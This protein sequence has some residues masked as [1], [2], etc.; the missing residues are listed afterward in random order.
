MKTLA[1]ILIIQRHQNPLRKKCP[2]TGFFLV[3][4]FPHSDWIRRDTEYLSVLSPNA[5]KYGPEKTAYLDTFHAVI[6]SPFFSSLALL[7]RQYIINTMTSTIYTQAQPTAIPT[8]WPMG[9]V[10][11][12]ESSSASSLTKDIY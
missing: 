2:Y 7:A 3:C 9:D 8:V 12:L 11:A 5:G 10:F 4:I 6:S 1:K